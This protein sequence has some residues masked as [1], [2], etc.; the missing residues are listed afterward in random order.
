MNDV[1][2]QSFLMDSLLSPHECNFLDIA[3]DSQGI[4]TH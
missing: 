3:P 2:G 1:M 4:A